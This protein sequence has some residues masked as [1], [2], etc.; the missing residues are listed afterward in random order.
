[1]EARGQLVFAG[2]PTGRHEMLGEELSI[3]GSRLVPSHLFSSPPRG[4]LFCHHHG[5]APPLFF[6]PVRSDPLLSPHQFIASLHPR[7]HS[8][9]SGAL[10]CGQ[11]HSTRD[12][13]VRLLPRW[14]RCQCRDLAGIAGSY[15]P[16][17]LPCSALS[18][19]RRPL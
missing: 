16:L 9:P 14:A 13:W 2:V 15:S 11:H 17:P 8:P 5:H 19:Y 18:R 1:M 7:L 3:S 10:C 12:G 4:V 6:S